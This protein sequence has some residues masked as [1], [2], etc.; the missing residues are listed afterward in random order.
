[1][2]RTQLYLSEDTWNYLHVRVRKQRTSISELVR[3]AVRDK[4]EP[5]SAD[6]REAM[7]AFV[8]LRRDRKDLPDSTVYIRK[9]RKGERLRRL[10][11]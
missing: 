9:L 8:G 2:K 7:E 1:M 11:R 10:T 6:R 5:M 3:L 4:Y